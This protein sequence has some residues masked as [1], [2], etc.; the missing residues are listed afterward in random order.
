MRD[1]EFAVAKTHRLV[2]GDEMRVLEKQANRLF[3]WYDDRSAETRAD[4]K[5]EMLLYAAPCMPFVQSSG[6]GKTKL[7][8]DFCKKNQKGQIKNDSIKDGCIEDESIED[9]GIEDE[10]IEAKSQAR[11]ND[12]SF[13]YAP[14]F[15]S[16]LKKDLRCK[17]P[18]PVYDFYLDFQGKQKK[19]YFVDQLSHIVD[20]ANRDKVVLVFDEAQE[21]SRDGGDLLHTLR[22]F[23]RCKREKD[24]VAFIAGTNTTLANCYPTEE[25]GKSSREGEVAGTHYMSGT[26]LYE[27]MFALY[28]MGCFQNKIGFRKGAT[29][30]ERAIPY[31]RPL[32]ARLLF[33]EDDGSAGDRVSM[34]KISDQDMAIIA[35]RMLIGEIAPF[36]KPGSSLPFASIWATRVQLGSVHA[37]VID[38]LVAQSYAHLVS[39]Q[40]TWHVQNDPPQPSASF[41]HMPDPVCARLAMC[42]MEEKWALNAKI[43]LYNRTIQGASKK[44]WIRK[45]KVLFSSG[46][47]SPS[48]GDLGELLSATYLLFCADSLRYKKDPKLETFS[49]S[50]TSWVER[51]NNPFEPVTSSTPATLV[52][53]DESC[54]IN[55]LQFCRNELRFGLKDVCNESFLESIYK[56]CCAMYA[57]ECCALYDAVAAIRCKDSGGCHYV[58][59]IMS[60]KT[61]EGY[62]DGAAKKNVGTI[63]KDL[64]AIG[65]MKAL[66]LMVLLDRD[67]PKEEEAKEEGDSKAKKD[68]PSTD[69]ALRS[70]KAGPTW[71]TIATKSSQ[72]PIGDCGENIVSRIISIPENDPFGIT[73]LVR[74]VTGSW[75][76]TSIFASHAFVGLLDANDLTGCRQGG[77]KRA[78]GTDAV[79]MKQKEKTESQKQLERLW[80]RRRD[81]LTEDRAISTEKTTIEAMD[82]S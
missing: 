48:R 64:V 28:T 72:L 20:S 69:R 25:Q 66:V 58:P 52:T 3:R 21:L 40:N 34:Y 8:Y 18:T 37:A 49:V 33:N 43:G 46:L 55:F 35:T 39:F 12:E 44:E 82:V 17:K 80:R 73:D 13:D 45:L 7:L 26:A 41:T 79:L 6:T 63:V 38:K 22:E 59:L 57:F 1:T 75:E 29:E 27:P 4:M 5:G 77:T 60:I 62:T 70:A 19:T 32:F 16:C 24:V 15:I 42:M 54:C 51:L 71:Q 14:K 53:D 36:Q 65:Q 30:F 76:G 61:R 78:Q 10:S 31:G 81:R 74:S 47:C 2:V 67:P 23:L 11:S 68:L 50:A 56:S 9:E